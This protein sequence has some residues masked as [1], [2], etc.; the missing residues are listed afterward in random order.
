MARPLRLE[1][2]GAFYHVTSRG[3]E[4]G[5]VYFKEEDFEKFKCYL[6]GACEKFGIVLHA[7][8]LMTNHYHLLIETPEA[9][10]GR[11]MHYINGAYTTYINIKK[12]RSGHLFQGR[13]KAIVVERD[14][15]LLEL[16]RYIHLNPVRAGMVDSPAAYTYSSYSAYLSKSNDD[17][18]NCDL[19]WGMLSKKKKEGPAKYR[20]FVETIDDEGNPFKEVYGG[21]VLGGN[22]FIKECLEQLKD[23]EI[24]NKEIS[25]RKQLASSAKTDLIIDCVAAYYKI[26][27]VSIFK[28]GRN[29]YK[30]MAVYLMKRHTG[31]SNTEIGNLFEISYSGVTKIFQRISRLIEKEGLLKKEVLTLESN[32]STVKG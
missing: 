15:Y 2:E 23:D 9:N 4:R 27:K 16:S 24:N 20:E 6:K 18:V 14:S 12:K 11:V 3:N 29:H 1:F 8:V 17:L 10:L 5:S 25:K 13:Y 7:Y 32:L 22:D 28:G 26:D 19:I 21:M 30:K 31:V